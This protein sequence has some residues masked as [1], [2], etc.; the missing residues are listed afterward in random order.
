MAS[1]AGIGTFPGKVGD[2]RVGY[3]LGLPRETE[4]GE[5]ILKMWLAPAIVMAFL[6][7][8]I[9]AFGARRRDSR[10]RVV[11]LPTTTVETTHSPG[12]R[13]GHGF[14]IPI[15]FTINSVRCVWHAPASGHTRH[16]SPG[17]R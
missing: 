3:F 6:R 12:V 17:D 8:I 5:R 15:A 1:G 16:S 10:I 2:R 4:A 9:S 7:P 14:H 13:R 11:R